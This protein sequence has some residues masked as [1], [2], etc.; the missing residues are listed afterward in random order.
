MRRQFLLFTDLTTICQLL[1]TALEIGIS[2]GVALHT[3]PGRFLYQQLGLPGTHM[4]NTVT[5]VIGLLLVLA[6]E[7][8]SIRPMEVTI[9]ICRC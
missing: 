9:R 2:T 7:K 8:N 5:A 6:G 3:E 4:E 1:Q